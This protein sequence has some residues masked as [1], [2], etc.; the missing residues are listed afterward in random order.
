MKYRSFYLFTAF[1]LILFFLF[2]IIIIM[3]YEKFII[4]EFR[5]LF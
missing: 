4:L 3:N 2:T 1:G 5:N